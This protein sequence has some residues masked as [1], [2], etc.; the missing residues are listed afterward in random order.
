[1]AKHISKCQLTV[2]SYSS[3][4]LWV[5]IPILLQMFI[6]FSFILKT[7]Q[8][9]L[10]KWL[11]RLNEC[12]ISAIDTSQPLSLHGSIEAYTLW[13]SYCW[14]IRFWLI[15]PKSRVQ[16]V[17]QSPTVT[18][19]WILLHLRLKGSSI[20]S[21]LLLRSQWNQNRLFLVLNVAISLIQS[22]T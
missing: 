5:E 7:H 3:Q 18:G 14:L 9:N 1:M 21:G 2:L 20:N 13:S 12:R 8:K 11:Y 19:Y 10:E 6:Y 17:P 4:S 16:E 15:R 22:S